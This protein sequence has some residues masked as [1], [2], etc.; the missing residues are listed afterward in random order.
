[1]PLL[2]LPLPQNVDPSLFTFCS[3]DL[4]AQQRLL[5]AAATAAAADPA[6]ADAPPTPFLFTGA[7]S[8]AA[9]IK[10]DV[11]PGMIAST[12][13]RSE[14]RGETGGGGGGGGR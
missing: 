11:A 5:R 4:P 13:V 6:C 2:P 14:L 9:A 8:L 12:Q 3:A 1:M 7:R 10:A